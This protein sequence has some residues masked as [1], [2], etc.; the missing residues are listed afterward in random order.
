MALREVTYY[1]AVCDFPDCGEEAEYGDYTAMGDPGSA[2]EMAEEGD[3][4]IGKT[5]KECYCPEHPVVWDC[6]IEEGRE[7]P[8]PPYILI[9]DRSGEATLVTTKGETDE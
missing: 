7:A 1:I 5:Q 6:D 9:E 4:R 2:I 8:S 3:W